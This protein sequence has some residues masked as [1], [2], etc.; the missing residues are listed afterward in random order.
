MYCV[1]YVVVCML[2]VAPKLSMFY[3][4]VYN[5]IC[6]TAAVTGP[7]ACGFLER[8]QKYRDL[9]WYEMSM[10]VIFIRL[11]RMKTMFNAPH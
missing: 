9:G 8:I 5:L 2:C 1:V 11:L 4:H 7:L 3:D 6:L 10:G